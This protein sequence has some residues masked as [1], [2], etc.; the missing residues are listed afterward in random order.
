[1]KKNFRSKN[2]IFIFCS[3]AAENFH[4]SSF[5]G[6]KSISDVKITVF[7]VVGVLWWVFVIELKVPIGKHAVLSSDVARISQMGGGAC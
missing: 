7:R 3:W 2:R 6:S 4:I 1:M 5:Y